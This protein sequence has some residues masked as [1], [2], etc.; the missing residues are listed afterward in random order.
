MADMYERMLATL[1]GTEKAFDLREHVFGILNIYIGH[2]AIMLAS[3][4]PPGTV[5]LSMKQNGSFGETASLLAEIVPRARVQIGRG[6]GVT[7]MDPS[8]LQTINIDVDPRLAEAITSDELMSELHTELFVDSP[9]DVVIRDMNSANGTVVK[10][11]AET[12][13]ARRAGFRVIE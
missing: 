1:A 10:D 4:V 5:V 9:F 7:A 12:P 11:V 8:T 3:N 13:E 6:V 2:T